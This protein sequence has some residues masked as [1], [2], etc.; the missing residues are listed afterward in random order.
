MERA[1]SLQRALVFIL[2]MTG[3]V[4]VYT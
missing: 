3:C 1:A 2:Q 4:R